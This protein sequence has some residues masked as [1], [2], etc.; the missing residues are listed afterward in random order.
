MN[1]AGSLGHDGRFKCGGSGAD[2]LEM[3]ELLRVLPPP[4]GSAAEPWM[5]MRRPPREADSTLAAT[6]RVWLRRLPPGR[7]PLRLCERFAR[8]AN[9][10]AWC[11][12]DA[13]LRQ[14]VL[15]DLLVD[16]RGGRT[17]FPPPVVAELRRLRDFDQRQ[18]APEAA[19][20]PHDDGPFLHLGRPAAHAPRP[21]T[22]RPAASSR[23]GGRE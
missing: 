4:E 6:T 2:S 5:P 10:I 16:R 7:R 15:E 23:C 21:R 13:D 17:G 9:R 19:S 11:W 12:P 18:A 1:A 3:L 20:P 14:Q 8:V 22:L